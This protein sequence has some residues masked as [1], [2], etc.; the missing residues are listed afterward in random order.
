MDMIN[1]EH[2]E[3]V[4]ILRL[5]NGVT[6]PLNLEFLEEISKNLKK[7][8]QDPSVRSVVVTSANDK[9]FSIGFDIP[10]LYDLSREEVS[11]FYQAYNRVCM[12]LYTFPK[13]TIAAITGH[14]I[15]GGCILTL[16]CDLRFIAEGKKL[17]GL[18]EIKLGVPV[19]YPGD[20]ILTQLVGTRYASDIMNSGEFYSTSEQLRMGMVD[21][22]LPL[23]QVVPESIDRI[24]I[25]GAMPNEGFRMIKRNRV[26]PVEEQVFAN[27]A[28]KEQY[29]LG[30]WFSDEARKR[31]KEAISKF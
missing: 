20:R 31:L 7:L 25:M 24:R 2:H 21:F 1:V 12:D 18:N 27:L 3:K 22:V 11:I 23:K 17:M 28:E 8:K 26:E 19:P 30:C 4:A 10:K 5:N 13:P 9:F 29:F 16:C 6:N 15:A 14:A